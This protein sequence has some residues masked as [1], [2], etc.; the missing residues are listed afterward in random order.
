MHK[1]DESLLK[2]VP[3]FR[4][5]ERPQIREILDQA[6]PKRHDEGSAVFIEGHQ[7]ERFYLLLDGFIRVMR[8]TPGGER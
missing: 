5:L 3:P 8:T 1:L 7:A 6:A 4:R 2:D